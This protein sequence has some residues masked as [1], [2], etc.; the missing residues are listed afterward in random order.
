MKRDYVI[1]IKDIL[2]AIDGIEEFVRGMKFNK[3]FEG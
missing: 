2:D 1:Y 3:F